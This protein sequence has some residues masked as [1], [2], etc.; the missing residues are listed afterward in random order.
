MRP[1]GIPVAVALM[2]CAAAVVA[3]GLNDGEVVDRVYV[4]PKTG[5]AMLLMS[6]DLP[7]SQEAN[8][9][10]L[11]HKLSTYVAFVE[12]GQLHKKYPQVKVDVPVAFSLVFEQPP[13]AN[14]IPKLR[15]MKE[16][17]V[18][19]GHEVQMK[20]VDTKLNKLV[21]LEP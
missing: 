17:L 13:P 9:Y 11:S 7:L 3:A 4:H 20:V 19:K 14:V 16:R 8:E 1:I 6:V 10:K 5:Q 15:A 21:D 12:S 18:A 2:A